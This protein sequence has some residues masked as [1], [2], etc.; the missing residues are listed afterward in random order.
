MHF[1]NNTTGSASTTVSGLPAGIYTVN[2]NMIQ[3]NLSNSKFNFV[4]DSVKLELKGSKSTSPKTF[5]QENV[6]VPTKSNLSITYTITGASG[7]G[8]VDV[9][10]AGLILTAPDEKA[11]Y[12]DLI[13]EQQNKLD[14]LILFADA[15]Q[16][17]QIG[18]EY[19]NLNGIAV[20][21]PQ[22]GEI[23]IKRIILSNG[24]VETQIELIK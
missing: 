21:A 18:V 2:V 24:Q 23:L 8:H 7:S 13:T 11:N 14:E 5:S 17:E 4:T 6:W 10:S 15:P 12:A 19:I 9:G 16:A 20:E 22:A 1:E 3:N